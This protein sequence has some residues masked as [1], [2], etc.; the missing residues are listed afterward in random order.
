MTNSTLVQTKYFYAN[1]RRVM[2]QSLELAPGV[3]TH[4]SATTL[5]IP[6]HPAL[7]Y[8]IHIMD[9]RLH[10][11]S[12]SPEVVPRIFRR[13][14]DRNVSLLVYMKVMQYF[15]IADFFHQYFRP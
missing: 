12:D 1:H 6:L 14:K 11:L 3:L 10:L 4:I 9:P 8:Y 13:K 15:T 5:E 2:G 7:V